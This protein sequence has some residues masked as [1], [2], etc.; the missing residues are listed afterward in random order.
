MGQDSFIGLVGEGTEEVREERLSVNNFP[1]KFGCTGEER[2]REKTVIR[3]LVR[4]LEFPCRGSI[5]T[6]AGSIQRCLALPTHQGCY[7]SFCEAKVC[8]PQ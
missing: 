2:E 7:L 8:W 4:G 5:L 6:T 1:K 3:V